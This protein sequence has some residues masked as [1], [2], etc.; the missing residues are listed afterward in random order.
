MLGSVIFHS[1]CWL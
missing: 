1:L